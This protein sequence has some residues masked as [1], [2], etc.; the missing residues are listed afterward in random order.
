MSSRLPSAP[1]TDSTLVALYERGQDFAT[2][3][4]A[5]RARRE[6][7]VRNWEQGRVPADALARARALPGRW[8]ILAVALD[9]CSDSVNTIPFLARLAPSVASDHTAS[10][11]SA[12]TLPANNER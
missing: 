11:G 3:Y 10:E 7:W 1:A 12:G 4:A 5:A 2:F 8:R 9:A 6:L